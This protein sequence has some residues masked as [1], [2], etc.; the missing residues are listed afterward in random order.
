MYEDTRIY[1]NMSTDLR[2]YG[3]RNPTAVALTCVPNKLLSLTA[4]HFHHS[5]DSQPG[6]VTV[7]GAEVEEEVRR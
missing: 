3:Q 6:R 4:D 5:W 7:D 1:M 2:V